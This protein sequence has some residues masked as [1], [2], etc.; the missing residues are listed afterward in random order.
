M[1]F[2][3]EHTFQISNTLTLQNDFQ[4]FLIFLKLNCYSSV[5]PKVFTKLREIQICIGLTVE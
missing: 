4:I 5:V 2:D 3:G 1:Y